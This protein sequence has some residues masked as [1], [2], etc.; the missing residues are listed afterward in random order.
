LKW[1]FQEVGLGFMDWI[2]LAQDND[3]GWALVYSFVNI[4]F[5]KMRGNY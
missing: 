5:H 1:I 2:F 3:R 4:E